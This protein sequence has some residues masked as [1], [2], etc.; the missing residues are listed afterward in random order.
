MREILN[1]LRRYLVTN[2]CTRINRDMSLKLMAHLMTVPL[3]TLSREKVGTLHGK[4]FRSVD[5]L[6]RFL[7]RQLHGV[8]PR[9]VYRT[10][11]PGG[12][13][14]QTALAGPGHGRRDPDDDLF[15]RS[16]SCMSQKGVRLQLMRSCEEID[17]AVVEQL[18]RD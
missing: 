7:R 11:R 6:V 10:V 9:P 4:I 12:H 1:V 16:V 13:R 3:A 14:R 18:E 5:G 2:T 17:G 15:S 8:H